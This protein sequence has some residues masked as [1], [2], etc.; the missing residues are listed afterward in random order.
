[1][2]KI[3]NYKTIFTILFI[4]I[5]FSLT[6]CNESPSEIAES[7]NKILVGL[8]DSLPPMGFR[9][10][11]NELQGFDIDMAAEIGK[12]L[13]KEFIFTPYNWD[14]IL[15]GLQSKKFDVI[16]SA[17][18]V[19][20]EREKE[21]GFTLPYLMEKQVIVTS[22]NSAINSPEDLKGK[23][24]GIQ[25]GSTSY[26]ALI[27]VKSTLKEVKEYKN[28]MD[29]INDLGTGRLEA[30]VIDELVARYYL[31]DHGSKYRIADKELT[32]EPVAIGVRKEDTTL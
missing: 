24:V 15:L 27:P 32:K 2:K 18:S 11:S 6:A 20:S 9:S 10:T 26:N 7:S 1:M 22:K 12:K 19:T 5:A 30:V 21:I 16:I 14:G 31:K 29:A 13:N 28:N 25:M 4:T 3:T 17:L 23:V 8:D